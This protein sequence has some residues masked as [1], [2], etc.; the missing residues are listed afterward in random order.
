[1]RNT[2][3]SPPPNLNPALN[4]GSGPTSF[5]KPSSISS[6]IKTSLTHSS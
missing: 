4:A 2:G 5:W 3:S 6:S 1:M